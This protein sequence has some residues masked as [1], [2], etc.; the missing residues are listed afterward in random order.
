LKTALF[1]V[2][3]R[4]ICS[5]A[6]KTVTSQPWWNDIRVLPSWSKCPAKTQRRSSPH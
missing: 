3:G 6:P 5:A 2:I 4:A 1:P